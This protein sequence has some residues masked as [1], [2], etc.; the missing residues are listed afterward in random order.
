MFQSFDNITFSDFPST[1]YRADK[2]I[3][4]KNEY[5]SYIVCPHCHK[6]YS[7]DILDNNIKHHIKC[8][9]NEIITKKVRTSKGEY[10]IKP[11]KVY[12]Y[13]LIIY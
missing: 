11:I 4:I 8:K 10:L 5:T 9:C 6:F 2:L 7:L 3:G 12:P 1:I 13:N